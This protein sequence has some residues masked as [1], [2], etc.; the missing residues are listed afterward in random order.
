MDQG[1]MAELQDVIQTYGLEAWDG[2]H[3]NDPDVLDGENFRLEMRF[4]DGWSVYATG[5]NAF[6]DGYFDA[7]ARIDGIFEEEKM[8][9][10]AGTYRY[11]G[12]GLGGDFTITLNEDG[13]YSFYEGPLSSYLG[14]GVWNTWDNAVYM[15]EDA[16]NG[17]DLKFIF[18]VED[19][20][21]RYMA[22]NSDEFLY[23]KVSD[24]ERFV[25][26]DETEG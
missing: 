1:L 19:E 25:R 21:L 20:A 16:E 22:M 18:G 11:E 3:E 8:S 7:M 5:E 6:P 24:G 9:F 17:Y 10:L 2:F 4:A 23:V 15:T 14:K 12:E 26:Q 13:T